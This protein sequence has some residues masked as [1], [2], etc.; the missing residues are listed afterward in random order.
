MGVYS[1][2]RA[3]GLN[4]NVRIG[5]VKILGY[6][7]ENYIKGVVVEGTIGPGNVVKL[8]PGPGAAGMVVPPI[9]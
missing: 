3:F 1:R 6:E 8:K 5:R 9:K 2:D 4:E 7:G